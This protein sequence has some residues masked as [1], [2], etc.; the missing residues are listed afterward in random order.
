DDELV[1]NGVMLDIT[2]RKEGQER[3]RALVESHPGGVLISAEGRYQYANQA[4][5]TILGADHP[6]DL[7]G[8][9]VA[10]Q[11][12]GDGKERIHTRWQAVTKGEA[13]EPWEHEIEGLDGVRRTIVAQS[14]PI[15]YK[16]QE[17]AQTVIRDV[18]ERKKMEEELRKR[19]ER[20]RA[21]TE[22]VSE[23]I[24]RST[25]DEGLIFVN[26]AFANMFGY[27]SV[28]AI[29]EADP[30]ALYK[31]VEERE[32]LRCIARQDG[33]F[34]S[35]EVTYQRR[36]GSTFTGLTSGTVVKAPDGTVAFFDGAIADITGLKEY[37][38]ALRQE[39]DR[40]ALLLKNL[41][42][43]V[44]HGRPVDGRFVVSSVNA[45]F[46]AT[47]GVRAGEIQGEDLHEYIVPA[48]E[49]EEAVR[50]DR[51]VVEEPGRQ[52]EVRRRTAEGARTFRVQAAVR[53]AADGTPEVFAIYTDITEQKQREQKLVDA[54]EKAEKANRMKSAFLANMSHEIRTP[55]TSIIGFAEAI[56]DEVSALDARA[57]DGTL[58]LSTLGRFSELIEESG[59]RLLETLD[60]ILNL[61]KL[62]A[63]EMGLT[64][65]PVDLAAEAQNTVEQMRPRAE[66]ADVKV[67]AETGDAP[68]W[69]WAD[70]RG[71]QIVLRN[72]VSNA[73]K[74]T[75]TDGSVRVRVQ[76][77][78]GGDSDANC[79]VVEVEDTGI[80]MEPDQ[81]PEL[82]KPFRQESEGAAREYQGTGLGLAV[83][84]QAVRQMEGEVTVAT[85]KG[86]GS[87]FTV[88]LPAAR[89]T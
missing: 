33:T 54:K 30:A 9:P 57:E 16:G 4:A 22:N 84:Q 67:V 87:C 8:R 29:L 24:Y 62:E 3:W 28:E 14:V 81:V 51:A 59:K 31:N 85:E 74:Y 70:P 71:V 25:P 78:T 66:E 63:G 1:F 5:A 37:E 55:L 40:L 79:T 7:I 88:R 76:S 13:T 52:F 53:D 11:A 68:V 49:Q 86:E 48:G 45:T 38:E 65:E 64:P 36:D 72:L 23:G 39:R 20:L 35:V 15:T 58:D 82:F 77:E 2:A 50:I 60:G 69:A 75:E 42:V 73:V 21:I 47:F 32:R 46:E 43:S 12:L 89:T 18:T 80:G 19:E 56:G 41:P 17:A 26:Q 44:V 34:D 6:E 83:T 27:G 61:S 10:E